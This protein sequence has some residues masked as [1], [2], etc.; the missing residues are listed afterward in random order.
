MMEL[1]T[2][3]SRDKL[4]DMINHAHT[5]P[6]GCFVEIGV[7]RGGSALALYKLGRE[8]HLFDTFCGIP[9]KGKDDVVNVGDFCI[10]QEEF[11]N[12]KS[13]M[14]AARFHK[15]IFPTTVPDNL[16]PI[17]FIHFDGDQYE[18][19]KGIKTHLWDKVVPGGIIFIDDYEYMPSLRKAFA[20]DFEEPVM[21]SGSLQHF[22]V[23]SR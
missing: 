15:G 7:Y 12:M 17:A 19:A 16:P 6:P 21:T 10:T 1:S 3:L 2:L 9:H 4:N 18:T 13:A 8:I 22:V 23:K 5:S 14:P 20:E 11:D